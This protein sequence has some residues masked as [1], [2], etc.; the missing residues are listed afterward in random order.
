MSTGKNYEAMSNALFF[1]D[2]MLNSDQLEIIQYNPIRYKSIGII[3]RKVLHKVIDI[4]LGLESSDDGYIVS[5]IN[6]FF[7]HRKVIKFDYEVIEQQYHVISDI[8]FHSIQ[9][10]PKQPL[11]SYASNSNVNLFRQDIFKLFPNLKEIRMNLS[12]KYLF[13]FRTFTNLYSSVKDWNATTKII[14][15]N[16]VQAKF[17]VS[18]AKIRNIFDKNGLFAFF[19][20]VQGKI[21]I[22]K[23]INS[24]DNISTK[25]T[26]IEDRYQPLLENRYHSPESIECD[27]QV[28]VKTQKP[29]EMIELI[30]G[31]STC[32]A[33]VYLVH[34]TFPSFVFNVFCLIGAWRYNTL[35]FIPSIYSTI[36]II[37]FVYGTIRIKPKFILYHCIIYPFTLL[38]SIMVVILVLYHHG[39]WR[40]GVVLSGV[41][42]LGVSMICLIIDIWVSCLLY[43]RYFLYNV[44]LWYYY[45]DHGGVRL[46]GL[47]YRAP[48]TM[49]TMN[50]VDFW[51]I[52]RD[53]E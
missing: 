23:T 25:F 20:R 26:N 7:C 10:Q 43:Q 28:D 9:Q 27:L 29:F 18:H 22:Q 37:S 8:L 21:T 50:I 11:A 36:S 32:Y 49:E 4:K 12:K 51:N 52:R 35:L 41:L 46:P 42:M 24:D 15:K 17:V 19:D 5:T 3:N 1:F 33:Y 6:A 48:N 39:F 34:F 53:W 31:K 16:L 30:H 47:T 44:Y 2:A 14:L 45:F 40:S 13:S 38:S